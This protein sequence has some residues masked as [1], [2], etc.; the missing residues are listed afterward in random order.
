MK[1][2]FPKDVERQYLLMCKN[3]GCVANIV[4]PDQT[5]HSVASD[6]HLQSLLKAVPIFRAIMVNDVFTTYSQRIRLQRLN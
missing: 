2:I 1:N 4:Y 5:C 6:L 3:A